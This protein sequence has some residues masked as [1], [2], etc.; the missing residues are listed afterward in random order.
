[1]VTQ[2]FKVINMDWKIGK[3]RSIDTPEQVTLVND[4]IEYVTSKDLERL[5]KNKNKSV[6]RDRR[7]RKNRAKNLRH[8][9]R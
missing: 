6:N 3:I 7:R 5:K 9:I 8:G 4:N 1:M 2:P